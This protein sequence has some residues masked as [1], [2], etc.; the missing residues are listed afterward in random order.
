MHA[1]RIWDIAADKNPLHY[2]GYLGKLDE[3]YLRS[4]AK[5]ILSNITQG[6]LIDILLDCGCG[7]CTYDVY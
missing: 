6:H 5:Q 1:R 4:F 3:E 2:L 7:I